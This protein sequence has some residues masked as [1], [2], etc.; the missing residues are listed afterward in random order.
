MMQGGAMSLISLRNLPG[1][2]EK[3]VK[4]RARERGLS[5]NRAVLSLL[6]D[7]LG[8]PRRKR[9]HDDLDRLAGTWSAADARA[10]EAGLRK[11]RRIDPELWA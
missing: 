6:E 2:V 7:A 4:A 5:L 11:Q 1:P 9:R 10:F 3:A 8:G